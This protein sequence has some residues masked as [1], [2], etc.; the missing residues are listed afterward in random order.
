LTRI[1][2]MARSPYMA[3][4]PARCNDALPNQWRTP[5]ATHS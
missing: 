2:Y 1:P 4:A 5:D 3:L